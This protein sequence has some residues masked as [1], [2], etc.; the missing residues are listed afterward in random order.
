MMLWLSQ[1]LVEYVGAFNVFGYVTVRALLASLTAF[2]IGVWAGPAFIRRARKFA[3]QPVREDGPRS[4]LKKNST[5][6][7]GGALMLAVIFAACALWGDLQSVYL[8][9]AA[10]TALAFGAVGLADDWMKIRR[11][12]SRGMSARVKIILQS[13][14]AIAALSAM[15]FAGL[16]EGRDELIVPYTKDLAL[17]LGAAGMLVL[18]YFAIVGSSNAV[19]LT[20]GL[21]GLVIVPVMLA[22]GGLA[23]YA[24]VSGHAV[25]ADYLGVPHLPGAHELAVFCAALVGAGLAFLWFNAHP[26]AIF[27]GDVGA[28]SL[29]ASLGLVA[30][31]VRQEIVY[32]LMGGIFVAEAM[33]VI[34]QVSFFKATG[35]RRIFR[36]SPLHHHFELKG[37]N[38]NQVVV[39]FWII[40]LLLVMVGLAGLKIR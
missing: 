37:W 14:L 4:H 31:L 1:Q 20:D 15:S 8:W 17:P 18:G 35:G 39:R 5:P 2:A 11:A 25:F 33:S 28:L 10:A 19:N 12:H 16:S 3:A 27:M 26:A 40:S 34:M 36:M 22:A 13:M 29:G 24:Y 21:D 32:V 23:V 30:V 38:E 9:L 6:T 7:L